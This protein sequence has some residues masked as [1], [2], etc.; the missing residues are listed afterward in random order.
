MVQAQTGDRQPDIFGAPRG[1]IETRFG[2]DQREFL[3]PVATGYVAPANLAFEQRSDRLEDDIS[4]LVSERVVDAFESI[5]IDQHHRDRCPAA[6]APQQLARKKLTQGAPVVRAGE[7][8]GDRLLLQLLLPLLEREG[9]VVER[10]R[11][12]AQLF[13]AVGNSRSGVQVAAAHPVGG[14]KEAPDL[15]QHEPLGAVPD[16]DQQEQLAVRAKKT[17]RVVRLLVLRQQARKI[18]GAALS[19]VSA[20]WRESAKKRPSSA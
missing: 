14:P 2:Q 8:I 7:R 16:A 11:K 15:T 19:V 13:S 18:P 1:G 9:H 20:R 4:G 5:Q 12:L 6:P 3:A 10:L 17:H